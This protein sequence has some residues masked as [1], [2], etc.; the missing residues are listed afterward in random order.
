MKFDPT[1][2]PST[3]I[4]TLVASASMVAFLWTMKVDLAVTTTKVAMLEKEVS[5]LRVAKLSSR[6]KS[7]GDFVKT[8][9]L[10]FRLTDIKIKDTWSIQ[11]CIK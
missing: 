2:T 6:N 11:S 1:I 10:D 8:N 5:E 9:V 7:I 3:I 4:S